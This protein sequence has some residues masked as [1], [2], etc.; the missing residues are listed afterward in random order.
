MSLP[1]PSTSRRSLLT[2][3][4]ALAAVATGAAVV[5]DALTGPATA[6]AAANPALPDFAPVPAASLGPAVN[7]QDYFVGRVKR[8]LYWITDGTYQAAFLTTRDGVVLFDAPPTIG[9][10]LQRAIDQIGA[11]NG[12][13]HK[14]TH[15]VYSHHQA[16]HIGAWW[17]SRAAGIY[18]RPKA[19]DQYSEALLGFLTKVK[20]TNQAEEGHSAC[21]SAAAI[22]GR[23]SIV[24]L[25]RRQ[26]ER[27]IDTLPPGG[28]TPSAFIFAHL[29]LP[30]ACDRVIRTQLVRPGPETGG[31]ASGIGGAGRC[32]LGDGGD[33]HGSAENVG[34]ELHEQVVP[35]HAAVHAQL[36]E[37]RESRVG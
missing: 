28:D 11:D 10:N 36:P 22:P 16:D 31:K 15:L 13:S 21:P 18:S 23:P 3:G 29:R 37:L 8:N 24:R 2:R 30:A 32:H 34:L 1:N 4:A 14:V 35:G 25:P 27:P 7:E 6:G 17:R 19:F 12:V 20:I 33:C 9:H 26:V 5:G